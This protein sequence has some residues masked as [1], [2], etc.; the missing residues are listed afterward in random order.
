VSYANESQTAEGVVQ[1]VQEGSRVFCP[2][3]GGKRVRR[4]ERKG[5]MQ[6]SVFPYFGFFPWYCRECRKYSMIRKRKGSKSSE[7]QYVERED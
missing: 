1:K 3:C 2:E 4:V 7:E 5:F 6:K